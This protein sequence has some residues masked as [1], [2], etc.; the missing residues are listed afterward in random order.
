MSPFACPREREVA[1]LV[2][3]GHWPQACPEDLRAHV[4]QCRACS[5]LVLV[6]ATFQ[7]ARAQSA[8]MPRL[9]S[10]GALWWRAQLRRRNA[11]I[12]RIGRPLLGAQIFAFAVTLVVAVGA[13]VWQAKQ[14]FHLVSWLVQLPQALNLD[15]LLPAS[16]PH[17]ESGVWL[18]VPVLATVALLGGVVVYLASEKQ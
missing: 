6:T 11:A 13:I 16:R 17:L 1:A 12:E 10:P 4:D 5:D 9:E 14:G 15:V 2:H 8:A 3:Q 18:L 7:S